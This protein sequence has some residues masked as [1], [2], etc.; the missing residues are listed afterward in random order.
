M[1]SQHLNLKQFIHARNFAAK[2]V[3]KTPLL[4]SIPLSKKLGQDLYLKC[5]MLQP[6]GAF[7]VRGAANKL[8]NL[9][10]SKIK[11]VIAV[12][13]G[14]HGCAVAYIAQQLGLQAYIYVSE[15]V[16]ENKLANIKQYG[17]KII[18]TGNSQDDAEVEARKAAQADDGELIHPFDDPY[19]IAGQGTI[20]LEIIDEN[21]NIKTALIPLSGGGLISGM[22]CAIKQIDPNIQIIGISME[23]G[24]AMHESLKSGKPVEVGEHLS[25]ADSLQGGIGLNNQYTFEYT[26]SYVDDIILVTESE[27][28]SGM[29][30]L[31]HTH[32]FLVEGAAAVGVA[33]LLANKLP[34]I[35]GP[36][37]SVLSG[38]NVDPSILSKMES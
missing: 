38:N 5:E 3:K 31:L 14:N 32:K 23:K 17:A 20:S 36:C 19:I 28:L 34:E 4:H 26:K 24:A 22:A 37:V 35:K 30:Y 12:S 10:S 27:I 16:P 11:K 1:L 6:T 7:K 33:A 9:A 29:R 15:N 2:Y 13:T 21:P 18:V 25:L 8:C